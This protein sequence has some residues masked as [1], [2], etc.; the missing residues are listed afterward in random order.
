[1]NDEEYLQ[2]K[3]YLTYKHVP[4]YLPPNTKVRK[5]WTQRIKMN[6]CIQKEFMIIFVTNTKRQRIC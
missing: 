4:H 5:A 3:N 2:I 1:M 6:F